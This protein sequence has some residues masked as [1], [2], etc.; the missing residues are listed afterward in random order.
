MA[1]R[2]SAGDQAHAAVVEVMAMATAPMSD[3]EVIDWHLDADRDQLVIDARGWVEINHWDPQFNRD[4]ETSASARLDLDWL[5]EPP[6]T[7]AEVQA[8]AE[9]VGEWDLPEPDEP[10]E[11][12]SC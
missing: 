5:D 8:I 7:A 6:A 11:D 9:G 10:D 12:R 2:D 4:V 1:D 3:V